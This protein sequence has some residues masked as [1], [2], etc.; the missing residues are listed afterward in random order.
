MFGTLF[1]S[2]CRI[3]QNKCGS[4]G[5]CLIYDIGSFRYYMHGV[6]VGIQGLAF[7]LAGIMYYFV[8]KRFTAKNESIDETVG[9]E[10]EAMLALN[11][12]SDEPES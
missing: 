9:I 5:A 8:V 3:W 2:T 4:R 11:S 12:K 1:D 6:T 7:L 10:K